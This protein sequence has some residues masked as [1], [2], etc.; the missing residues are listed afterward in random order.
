MDGTCRT[1]R[2]DEKY[3]QSLVGNV[4][5]SLEELGINGGKL[6]K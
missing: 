4:N 3:I 6:L 5:W 2:R 1:H